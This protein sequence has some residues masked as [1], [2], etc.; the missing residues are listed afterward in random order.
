MVLRQHKLG[1]ADRI[2]EV[3]R[4]KGIAEDALERADASFRQVA[5]RLGDLS[6]LGILARG[7]AVCYA[8]D[9]TRV[10]RSAVVPAW[11][12]KGRVAKL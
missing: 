4:E 6:P 12:E 1:E 9:G 7:Y 8:E 5:A 2:V 11:S 3:L 10:V